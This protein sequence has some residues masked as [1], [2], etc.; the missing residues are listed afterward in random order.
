MRT[1]KWIFASVALLAAVASTGVRAH[2]VNRNLPEQIDR[3]VQGYVADPGFMGSVLVAEKGKILFAKGYG[4]A[5]V[6]KNIPNTPDTQFGVGSITKQFTALLVTQLLEQG[7]LTLDQTVSDFVPAFPRDIGDRITVEML[8]CHTSGLILPE[9]IE[10]YYYA[11]SKDE[12]LQEYIKQLREDGLRFEPGKG[13]GYSNGGYFLLGLIIEKAGGKPYEEL[14]REQILDPL[15]MKDTFCDR[16]GLA[17]KNGATCYRRLPDRYFSWDEETNAYDPAVWGFGCGNMISTVR[18]LFKFSQALS[19]TR[20]LSKKHMDLYLKMRNVKTRRP[21]PYMSEGLIN[22]YFAAY[23]NGFVGEI[24]V[25]DD[26]AAEGKETLIWHDG[27]HKLFVSNHFHFMNKDQIIIICGNLTIRGEG[28][29]MAFKIH[30]LLNQRPFEDIRI[31]YS[32]TQYIEEDVAMHAGI[33]AAMDEYLRLKKDTSRFV[34]PDQG[35]LVRISK[36]VREE[37]GDMDNAILIL[38]LAVAE[39]PDSWQAYDALGDTYLANNDQAAAIQCFKKSL[40]LNPEN[41]HAQEMLKKLE[42]K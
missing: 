30:R 35:Y 18:D 29:E 31:R 42:I 24:S 33:P 26:P 28:D 8:L 22:E 21:I 17:L 7:K 37:L 14:L 36:I 32:L 13:Y 5:D 41:T 39:S 12:F 4:L 2:S 6:E 3:L 10:R 23:G 16:K 1:I 20:L 40:E 19:T 11:A 34:L 9:G 38:K 27:T 15:G 25:I